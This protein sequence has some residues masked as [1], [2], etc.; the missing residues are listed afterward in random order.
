MDK[1]QEVCPEVKAVKAALQCHQ[2]LIEIDDRKAAD[3]AG[4]LPSLYYTA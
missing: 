2:N 3:H 4:H 1:L